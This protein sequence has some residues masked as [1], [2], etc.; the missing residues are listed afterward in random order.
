MVPVLYILI[1]LLTISQFM[2]IKI[3]GLLAHR[4]LGSF[5]LNLVWALFRR[6]GTVL[7]TAK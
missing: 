1:A 3:S 6:S 5:T 2:L 4:L 7:F